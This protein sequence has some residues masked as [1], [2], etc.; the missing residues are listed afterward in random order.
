MDEPTPSPEAE[1]YHPA[2]PPP[3]PRPAVPPVIPSPVGLTLPPAPPPRSGSGWRV[4]SFILMG[5]IVLWV[6]GRIAVHSVLGVASHGRGGTDLTQNLEEVV[7]ERTNTDNKIAVVEVNGII[8]TGEVQHS[9]MD[10]VAYIKEQFKEAAG[11][12]DVKAVVLKV[13]SPGG[14]VLASDDI[15]DIIKKF[16]EKTGK[17]VVVS[18]GSLAASGGYY[19]SAPCRWIVAN[20]LTITG[21]IGVIMHNYNYRLLFDKIG[22]RPQVI[23][24]G[25]FKDMLSG[26][27]E[28]DDAKLTAQE[29]KDRDEEEKMVQTLIDET[30]DRFKEVVKTGREW[31]AQT[32]AGQGRPLVADWTNYADGRI[33]SGKTALEYGFV[34][35]LGNFDTAV[36][37][38]K[39]LTHIQNANLVEYRLPQDLISALLSHVL[40]QTEAPALKVDLGFDPP[41]LRP[42]LLYFITPTAVPH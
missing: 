18:M 27:R 29:I 2:P 37:R 7:I 8:S 9:D 15:H 26:E 25:R 6:L 38:A 22:V 33:L 36:K 20:E 19:I 42:G 32:N 13:N 1:S 34:D 4:L 12:P 10:L 23:K 40:G 17:P 35:E 31:A 11:D 39:T 21:S 5:L 14:E 41:K 24:S 30:F 3:P 16:E 28:P